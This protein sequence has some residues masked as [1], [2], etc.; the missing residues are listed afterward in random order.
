MKTIFNHSRKF[1]LFIIT[2]SILFTSA[3]SVYSFGMEYSMG[4]VGHRLY[5]G[6]V[7]AK[8]LVLTE[9]GNPIWVEYDQTGN[10]AEGGIELEVTGELE[11]SWVMGAFDYMYYVNEFVNIQSEYTDQF[12]V[13]TLDTYKATSFLTIDE[14][15][16]SKPE[17]PD[18]TIS[19][20]VR[21]QDFILS[22]NYDLVLFSAPINLDNFEQIPEEEGILSVLL[23]KTGTFIEKSVHNIG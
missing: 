3:K 22:D 19:V 7:G 4:Y 11:S 16:I 10:I 21:K 17:L 18:S 14:D 20:V 13:I 12:E 1:L 15:P 6:F 8:G 9:A 23:D 2:V 5:K